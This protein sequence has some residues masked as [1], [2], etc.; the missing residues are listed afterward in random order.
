[1]AQL[2]ERAMERQLEA[3]ERARSWSPRAVSKLEALL[4]APDDSQLFRVNALRFADARGMDEAE[5]IDLFLHA[6]KA[7]LFTMEWQ[8]ICP[9]CTDAVDTVGAL[10]AVGTAYHCSLC[11][12]DL[13][14]SLDDVIQVT[15]TV[16]PALRRL[17]FHDPGTLTIE[18]YC[19]GYHFAS[20]ALTADGRTFAEA[21]RPFV[22]LLG[23]VEPGET[24]R[25]ET[26][27]HPGGLTGA[28]RVS[29]AEIRLQVVAGAPSGPYRL[30]LEDGRFQHDGVL[31]TGQQTIEVEN[32]LPGRAA[33]V[34]VNVGEERRPPGATLGRFLSG[35]RLFVTQTFSD[36]F[37]SQTVGRHGGLGLKDLTVL[38]T[39]LKGSTG[40]YE[41]IGDLRAFQ[42]VDQHFERL[43]EVVRGHRGAVVKTIG[44]AVMATFAS[45]APA[46]A[47]ALEMLRSIEELNQSRG[48]RDVIL[49]IG[50]HT[51]PSIAVT[52]N[53][54]L[55]YFGQTV[56][57]AA[58]VQGVA[59]G[60]EI[61]A[62]D[63]VMAA[64]GVGALVAG[65]EVAAQETQLRGIAR[66]LRVHR[67]RGLRAPAG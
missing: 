38:F 6:T 34:A 50:L 54:R 56:N 25:F 16:S 41:R 30:R 27:L 9:L 44:D 48:A 63:A 18:E 65:H 29:R 20:R 12:A 52:L 14:T 46:L 59:E 17:R 60:D 51:G 13:E 61:C 2:D 24:A 57:I 43:G 33:V 4:R 58:R 62:T 26:E 10:G 8:L 39:D 53:E 23:Y 35:K 22:A 31:G 3:L 19:F 64:P 1:M 37:R 47:S 21:I 49:K 45:P 11:R 7:G 32:R 15:F 36:L 67:I 5:A 55:D 42:L 66:T 28:D 40:L